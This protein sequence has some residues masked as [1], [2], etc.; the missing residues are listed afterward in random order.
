MRKYWQSAGLYL[1]IFVIILAVLAFS[2][3]GMVPSEQDVKTY[4]YS[5][6]LRELEQ[7]TVKSVEI[8]RSKEV[9][10][11]AQV[12]ATLDDGTVITANAPSAEA[13]TALVN[14]MPAQ[15]SDIEIITPDVPKESVLSA[16]LPSLIIMIVM[17][18]LFMVMFGRMQGGGGK[19]ASF[20]KS[21]AKMNLDD[22]NKVT[23]DNVAG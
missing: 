12:T 1:L 15:G 19:M 23:F 7:D 22:K 11:Y 20:G 5:D 17:V 2:G 9:S 16:M 6:L 13:F 14:A 4:T 3:R 18:I 21:K 10:D 8:T